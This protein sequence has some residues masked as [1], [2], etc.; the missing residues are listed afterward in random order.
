MNTIKKFL[1]S[2]VSL[3][4]M[5][6]LPL[7]LNTATVKAAEETKMSVFS[8]DAGRKYFSEDQL[9]QI[10]KKAHDNGYTH[11]QILL[12]NDALRFVLDDMSLEVNG[13][14]YDS[15]AVKEAIQ[16]GNRIYY[17]DPN[18]NVLYESEMDEIIAYAEQL[19]ISIIPVINSPG[20]M[21]A[22]LDAM[23]ILGIENPSFEN[24]KRTV[25][26]RNEEAVAFTHAFVKKYVDYFSK[27]SEIFNM[28]CDEYANDVNTG[29]WQKLQSSGNYG[30]LVSYVNE[31]AQIIK[32][33]GMR[34]MCFNDG[35]YYNSRDSYGTFDSD[36]IISYWTA[37][38]WGYDVAKPQYFIDKGH[39]ILNTN[40]GWYW[41]L[42]RIDNGGY[43]YQ[44]AVN[45]IANK[46]FNDVPSGQKV[47]TIGS[48]QCV[49]CD[50]P[51][52]EHDMDRIMDLMDQ[53]SQRHADQLIRPA[54]YTAVKEA[55]E[56]VPAD[57]EAY[58]E[59]SVEALNAAIA[60]VDNT[61]KVNDQEKVDAMAQAILDAVAALEV[62]VV[63]PETPVEP[64]TKPEVKPE[65][66]PETPSKP[67]TTPTTPTTPEQ[68]VTPDTEEPHTGDTSNLFV[69]VA[70]L[71]ASLG[72][73]GY[74]VRKRL[75]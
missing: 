75:N 54:D 68:T 57:L 70:A 66:K 5:L 67:E 27:H 32:D 44:G 15:E 22:I 36:I 71:L 30:K 39:D 60:A 65:V 63:E 17:D 4:M 59:E 29:G 3:C 28:G 62:K 69:F 58:T 55:L 25:D 33:A 48:M 16:E 72:C 56:T 2:F 61:L 12:G 74:A 49:W 10:V 73:M 34:P 40:D 21:D 23:K 8:I 9:K 35:I 52:A 7:G 47:E 37:G 18:G 38:W 50:E 46:D 6:V 1:V 43:N 11:V 45:N 24:S 51:N 31:L 41:V 26:I 64:E 14:S 53:F 42:G 20:H 13:Q 19:N